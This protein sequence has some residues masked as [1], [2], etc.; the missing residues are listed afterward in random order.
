MDINKLT[1]LI[2]SNID[3]KENW[4]FNNP[5]IPENII[6]FESD[7]MNY[8]IGNGLDNY[9]DLLYREETSIYQIA[10]KYGYSGSQEQF[11][12]SFINSNHI[13]SNIWS[14]TIKSDQLEY[15][16]EDSK[17]NDDNLYI[18]QIEDKLLI[19]GIDY[20]VNDSIITLAK[21][22][23]T[24]NILYIRELLI[25]EDK[26]SLLTEPDPLLGSVQ[27]FPISTM[28]KIGYALADGSLR[29]RKD[30]PDYYDHFGHLSSEHT[31]K[32]N[33]P[34][35]TSNTSPVGFIAAASSILGSTTPAYAVFRKINGLYHSASGLPVWISISGNKDNYYRVKQYSFITRNENSVNLHAPKTWAFQGCETV[36][37]TNWVTLDTRTNLSLSYNRLYTYDIADWLTKGFYAK[38][39]LYVTASTSTYVALQQLVIYTETKDDELTNQ[40][41]YL[42]NYLETNTYPDMYPYIRLLRPRTVPQIGMDNYELAKAEGFTGT[43]LEYIDMVRGYDAYELS[44]KENNFN[45][46]REEWFKSFQDLYSRA[47]LGGYEGTEYEFNKQLSKLGSNVVSPSTITNKVLIK[48]I[49]IGQNLGKTISIDINQN[50][51]CKI[52]IETQSHNNE[53]DTTSQI[54]L[55]LNE[56]N[57]AFSY[58]NVNL[59]AATS[60]SASAGTVAASN[61]NYPISWFNTNYIKSKHTINYVPN[62]T[63]CI[64]RRLFFNKIAGSEYIGDYVSTSP[65]TLN[66]LNLVIPVIPYSTSL[67]TIHIYKEIEI[68]PITMH[69]YKEIYF[70]DN[71]I[72]ENIDFNLDFDNEKV[73]NFIIETSCAN[74]VDIYDGSNKLVT[75]T[76]NKTEILISKYGFFIDNEK[77]DIS[78]LNIKSIQLTDGF[79]KISK[80][81]DSH[82]V[83]INPDTLNGLDIKYE[84]NNIY[85]APGNIEI[86]NNLYYNETTIETSMDILFNSDLESFQNK[87]VYIYAHVDKDCSLSFTAMH[88]KPVY[89]RFGNKY[90]NEN[91]IAGSLGRFHKNVFGVYRAIGKLDY[92][93]NSYIVSVSSYRT[94]YTATTNVTINSNI[95]K[96]EELTIENDTDFITPKQMINYVSSNGILDW[97]FVGN[98]NNEFDLINITND[99]AK[100][101]LVSVNGKLMIPIEDY[102]I[103]NTKLIFSENI[104]ENIKI[105]VR[106]LVS[107]IISD[108]PSKQ[109]T[110]GSKIYLYTVYPG[111]L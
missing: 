18:C 27:L 20:F 96:T 38:F 98:N 4:S 60:I 43:R 15:I 61:S 59:S 58:Y 32:D 69:S 70:N 12:K 17:F 26:I 65:I 40:S 77:F 63:I 49:D 35:M 95:K 6:V 108:S 1:G 79:I 68:T 41:F 42:P 75:L 100:N 10:E 57:P 45:G 97:S 72:N 28:N 7:T 33:F 80:N 5:I 101:Y 76:K 91:E 34:V 51:S 82:A 81:I 36:N 9:E 31:V 14:I 46:T 47:K 66:K 104:G 55:V 78:S 109:M 56:N 83:S 85:I 16:L 67:G 103:V 25:L 106:C 88:S 94:N 21:Q 53:L 62:R 39:R 30:F 86:E 50:E 92:I 99:E 2:G 102:D 93:D 90:E 37:G 3:T 22:Y 24:G 11:W 74:N 13:T 71:L 48:K 105:Y 54:Y 44:V 19:P 64:E 73:E 89:D 23:T 29:E 111:G 107:G 110:V 52:I 87:D 8:K 84:N